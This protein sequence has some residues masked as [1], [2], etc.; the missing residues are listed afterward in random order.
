[1]DPAAVIPETVFPGAP[2]MR[3]LSMTVTIVPNRAL[4]WLLPVNRLWL[5]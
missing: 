3:S 5:T 2:M 4:L 1:M